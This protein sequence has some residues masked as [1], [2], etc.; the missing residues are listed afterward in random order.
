[1]SLNSL[2]VYCS[3]F[4]QYSHLTWL[5]SRPSLS[6]QT[7]LSS[8]SELR[9]GQRSTHR[10]PFHIAGPTVAKETEPFTL[11]YQWC[12][13]PPFCAPQGLWVS[14]SVV[15]SC[16][17]YLVTQMEVFN[18]KTA[19]LRE[20]LPPSADYHGSQQKQKWDVW[21]LGFF[22]LA[23]CKDGLLEWGSIVLHK[24]KTKF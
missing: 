3:T 1:M 15:W 16:L 18:F 11:E 14:C 4:P 17:C 6:G 19:D 20:Q 22:F 2:E 10:T 9:L 23:H 12:G 13:H 8:A 5:H 24:V 7:E 21:V